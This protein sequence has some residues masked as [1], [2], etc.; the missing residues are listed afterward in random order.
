MIF[1]ISALITTI[2]TLSSRLEEQNNFYFVI[3][4]EI[5]LGMHKNKHPFNVIKQIIARLLIL[6]HTFFIWTSMKEHASFVSRSDS[7][8]YSYLGYSSISNCIFW[9]QNWVYQRACWGLK[10]R[11]VKGI[12]TRLMFFVFDLA[13]HEKIYNIATFSARHRNN[14]P[15]A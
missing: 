6:K 11:L 3:Q 13:F 12:S 14:F 8:C 4:K 5:R 2:C 10:L 9:V 15:I 7:V 1:E